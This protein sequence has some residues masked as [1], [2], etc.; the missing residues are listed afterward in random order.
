MKQNFYRLAGYVRSESEM[1]HIWIYFPCFPREGIQNWMHHSIMKEHLP[2]GH[3]SN[4]WRDRGN[5]DIFIGRD[6]CFVWI[7]PSGLKARIWAV[8]G[9][10]NWKVIWILFL[11]L[12]RVETEPNNC[13]K[14]SIWG[15]YLF[16]TS[17]KYAGSWIEEKV[18][19]LLQFFRIF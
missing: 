18:S 14:Y 2:K 3:S 9:D 13:T 5:R 15:S 4:S 12:P 16:R 8:S 19:K 6:S 17:F 10:V 1:R 7:W 11:L